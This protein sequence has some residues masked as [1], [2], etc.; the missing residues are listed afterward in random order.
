M[1]P[2]EDGARLALAVLV[3]ATGD[4]RMDRLCD[5]LGV[6][7]LGAFGSATV[8]EGL[9][10]ISTWPPAGAATLGSSSCST[11]RWRSP[12]STASIW[13]TP[14]SLTPCSGRERSPAAPWAPGVFA[15]EQMAALAE[16]RDTEWLRRPDLDAL[17]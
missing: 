9:L 17:A 3:T 6:R 13:P 12:G 1:G 8:P 15:T 16:Q 10:V 14:T 11:D 4:T 5:P 7:I 2:I